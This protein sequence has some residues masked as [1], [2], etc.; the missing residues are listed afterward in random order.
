MPAPANVCA[1]CEP[2]ATVSEASIYN[3][4]AEVVARNSKVNVFTSL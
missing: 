3:V 1:L 2:G 4:S